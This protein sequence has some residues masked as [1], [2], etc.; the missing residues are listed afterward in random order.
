MNSDDWL[1]CKQL[2]D[3]WEELKSMSP[4]EIARYCGQNRHQRRP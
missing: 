3:S 4:E 1:F 2:T